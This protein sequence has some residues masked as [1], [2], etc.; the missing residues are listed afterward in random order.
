MSFNC[1]DFNVSVNAIHNGSMLMANNR[2]ARMDPWGIPHRV[3]Q[4]CF[5]SFT[6]FSCHPDVFQGAGAAVKCDTFM[7]LKM[8]W[9]C[10]YELSVHQTDSI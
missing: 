6:V 1:R 3:I 8:I 10:T 5:I 7:G 4:T 2:G 9:T